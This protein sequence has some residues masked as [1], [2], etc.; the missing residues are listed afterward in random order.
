MKTKKVT[1]VQKRKTSF[2]ND[3]T[4]VRSWIGLKNFG[5]R[6]LWFLSGVGAGIMTLSLSLGSTG[7][8]ENHLSNSVSDDTV[9][10]QELQEL[11]LP[12]TPALGF[13]KDLNRL[14]KA[15][16]SERF[17]EDPRVMM[18]LA[19]VH[20]HDPSA[21]HHERQKRAKLQKSKKEKKQ[22]ASK[23]AYKPGKTLS[24]AGSKG[25]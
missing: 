16:N 14:S 6:S 5:I 20:K 8:S 19:R 13:D 24:R 3:Q 9:I 22:T 11:D 17:R 18:A 10:Y 7:G 12:K 15:E 2:S 21:Y 1:P 4:P 25:K 23:R